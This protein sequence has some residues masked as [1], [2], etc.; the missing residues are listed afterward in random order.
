M[1]ADL[2][3]IGYDP[4]KTQ[5]VSDAAP[6]ETLVFADAATFRPSGSSRHHVVTDM[7]QKEAWQYPTVPMGFW[8]NIDNQHRYFRWLEKKIGINKI[9]DWYKVS[10][11]TF[12]RNSGHTLLSNY[13]NDSV[14]QAVKAIFPDHKWLPWNFSHVPRGFFSKLENQK[15]YMEWLSSQLEIN[16]M[17][18]WYSVKQS[19]FAKFRGKHFLQSQ[20]GG[21]VEQALRAVYVAHNWQSWKFAQVPNGFWDSIENQRLFFDWLSEKLGVKTLAEWGAVRPQQVVDAGGWRVLG[22]IYGRRLKNALEAIYPQHDW[23]QIRFNREG[24]SPVT[25]SVAESNLS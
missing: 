1:R 16:S 20:Y 21:N 18:K 15:A 19:D 4:T 14:P 17:D 12:R 11:M 5:A 7:S 13:Y 22:T 9:E 24:K 25:I 23:S 10:K 8:G 3:A 2:E 6:T